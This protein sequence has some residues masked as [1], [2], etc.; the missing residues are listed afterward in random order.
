MSNRVSSIP[1]ADTPAV[2][3]DVVL[4]AMLELARELEALHRSGRLQRDLGLQAIS[5]DWNAPRVSIHS[6]ATSE[7]VS[8]GGLLADP[9]RCPP[10]MRRSHAFEIPAEIEAAQR[11]LA[12]HGIVSVPQRIDLYQF[13][14]LLCRLITGRS[15]QSYL[16]S[17]G[18]LVRVP[19]GAR[20]VID[21]C[22]GYDESLCLESTSQL[23]ELINESLGAAAD[24]PAPAAA[25]ARLTDTNLNASAETRPQ[26]RRPP[27]ERLGH[28]DIQEEIGHGGMG[29]V[30]RA[31]DRSLDRVVA[32]K[33]LSRRLASDPTFV[34]RFQAEA[35]AAARLAHP[36]VVPIYFIG[37]DAGRHFYAMQFIQGES[38]ADRLCRHPTIA[39]AEVLVILQQVLQG[40]A[41]AHRIGLVH[42]DIKPGNILIDR[43]N[44]LAMLTDFGLARS[45]SNSLDQA[46]HRTVM[47]TAE[48][49][50]PEQAQGEPTDPRSDLYSV[51]VLLYQL[52]SGQM[53]FEADTPSSHL[54]HHVCTEPRPLRE[55]VPDVDPQLEAI[56]TRLLRK[57]PEERHA[58]VEKL[59]IDLD[60]ATDSVFT[61][62]PDA[63]PP[64][65]NLRAAR[66][67]RIRRLN[68]DVPRPPHELECTAPRPV[69]NQPAT[70]QFTS[71]TA[72]DSTIR[73]SRAIVLATALGIVALLAI[74][75]ARFQP[76]A[77]AT[78]LQ[79]HQDAVTALAF[80]P[81]GNWLLS[82]GGASSSL[83]TAGDTSLRLWNAHTG[84]LVK[85]SAR[86]PVRPRQVVFLND[87]RR[88]LAIASAREDAGALIVW[89]SHRGTLGPI[90]FS[91]PF[92]M[93]FDAAPLWSPEGDQGVLVVGRGGVQRV[94]IVGAVARTSQVHS[95]ADGATVRAIAVSQT[96]TGRQS[97]IAIDGPDNRTSVV[98]FDATS[99]G[100]L[101]RLN[102]GSGV[103][104]SLAI[105]HNAQILVTRM[106][107]ILQRR[108]QSSDQHASI[109][110]PQS[111]D[112]GTKAT[113]TAF[114]F[115][116][117]YDWPPKS[118][119]ATERLRFGPYTPGSRA[120]AIS[121]DGYRAL[122]IAEP[123]IGPRSHLPQDAV[124]LD[125]TTGQEIC[126]LQVSSEP[127]T[128]VALAPSGTRAALADA[129]GNVV[130]CDLPK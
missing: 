51:G 43:E 130:F 63:T 31:F 32:I 128:A 20:R 15:V 64:I 68:S 8:F 126:R 112:S 75:V 56:V 66:S 79:V 72:T 3:A 24:G 30:Y 88:V 115:V 27:F 105:S 2:A 22:L 108:K 54:I 81:D 71:S 47:G 106:T 98:S 6:Q 50:S 91:E 86:L 94:D 14:T 42:R 67:S 21:G 129:S 122:T 101:A 93:H 9:E 55:L 52:L 28:F 85:Q 1:V 96:T 82:G 57:L 125:L 10:E 118:A 46:D 53:P 13:G 65:A 39:V 62:S 5:I 107:E 44:G 7:T 38:L 49:M 18:V 59:L 103:I 35:S 114:D 121:S 127:L 119:D 100:E 45:T 89:D 17:P 120:M 70:A 61:N 33:V 76:N 92:S 97:F 12:S 69:P 11:V 80:S 16:S 78:P 36:N 77:V 99:G 83:K 73:R 109:R 74:A 4:R 29:T 41:A 90:E 37:E 25:S 58:S 104:T 19:A 124:C 117:V 111:D 102:C 87:S 116:R 95:P 84:Q 113:P 123:S 110:E 26:L 60:A 48:Y 34:K 23:I 40:L